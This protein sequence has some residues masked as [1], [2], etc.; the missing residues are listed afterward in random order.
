ME[1]RLRE[2][3]RLSSR[4]SD[5]VGLREAS[6]RLEHT[7]TQL[8]MTP[9]PELCNE[10]SA[11]TWQT[12]AGIKNGTLLVLNLDSPFGVDDTTEP[13]R[14]DPEWLYGE[15]I[16]TSRAPLVMLEHALM[17]LRAQRRLRSTGV[18]VLF[19]TDEGRDA[20]YSAEI[21]RK[22]AAQVK[23]VVVLRPGTVEGHFIRQRRGQRK[24]TLTVEGS[25]RRIGQSV[26]KPNALDWLADKLGAISRLSSRKDRLAVAV[27]DLKT[28]A[29]P[30][31]LPHRLSATL[32]VSY[33]DQKLADEVEE[34]VREVL[35]RKELKWSLELVSERPPMK[36]RVANKR[37][38]KSITDTAAEWEIDLKSDSSIWPSVGGLVTGRPAVVCGMGP[39]GRN[40]HTPQESIRRISLIRRTLVLAQLLLHFEGA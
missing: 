14:R 32:I 27:V 25:P 37:L 30:F 6:K 5:P 19:Y 31:L 3:V 9:V 10:H 8:G 4:T 1:K 20:R 34:R 17:A 40:L 36:D 24:Y 21:I 16:A 23:R 33:L 29:F 13:F 12:R 22:A 39:V 35:G 28:H 11:W 18:G 38:A 2:W 26:K 7:L 15:A